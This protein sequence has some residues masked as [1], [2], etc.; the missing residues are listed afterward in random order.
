MLGL[1]RLSYF[2][3]LA[4]AVGVLAASWL[5]LV[6]FFPAPPSKITIAT[7][8][9]GSSYELLG[10]RYKAILARSKVEVTVRLTNG[11]AENLRLLQDKN[12]GV[13]AGI[14]A[15][16]VSDAALSPDLRSLGRVN[17]L[18]FWVF[19]RSVD[20]WPDLP[21]LKGKRI[22][23]GQVG[24]DNQ[25][26]AKKLFELSGFNQ[27]TKVQP[28][29][30]QAAVKA[31]AEGQVDAVF[32]AGTPDAPNIQILLRDP[33]IRLMNFPR[34]DALSRIFP[35]LVHL[36]LPAGAIDFADNIP[37]ADINLIGT[38][39]AVLVR[40]NLHL[41]IVYLLTQAMMEVHGDAGLFKSAGE[42]PAPRDPEYPMADA[43]RDFYRNGP[44]FLN[45]YL[46]FWVVNYM[47]RAAAVLIAATA[48]VVP[49]FG[50]MP[51]L[52]TWFREQSLRRLYRRLRDIEDALQQELSVQQAEALLN[53]L[54]KIDQ[55]AS[56]VPM[57]DSHLFFVFR[58]HLDQ[59]R[60]RL[61]SRLVETR[62]KITKIAS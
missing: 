50:F 47:Q 35:F 9:A 43:A 14:V 59:T 32:I 2:G 7:A 24:S 28:L 26:V 33:N 16:G 21:S 49:I 51:W 13:A 54:D 61:T 19:Y 18:P 41:Q 20:I 5:A 30:G 53:D 15:G 12:S 17:Y 4:A 8:T 45:R 10:N 39:N 52:Y 22:A 23:V 56:V 38:T 44:T 29:A 60:S 62:D 27:E 25:I 40:N 36:V 46:P 34:A 3:G 48:V 37:P 58:Q 11:A 57:R 55:A 42:F 1:S 6:Y 31:L